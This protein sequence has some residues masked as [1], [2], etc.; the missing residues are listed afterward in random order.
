[1]CLERYKLKRCGERKDGKR[2]TVK[3]VFKSVLLTKYKL[4]LVRAHFR[5]SDWF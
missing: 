4:D 3:V 2:R 5:Y 1:M